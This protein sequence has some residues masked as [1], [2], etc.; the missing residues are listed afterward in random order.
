MIL[1]KYFK[2]TFYVISLPGTCQVVWRTTARVGCGIDYKDLYGGKMTFIVCQYRFPGNIAGL[3]L[4]NIMEL[5]SGGEAYQPS[6]KY[7]IFCCFLI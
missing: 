6:C 7:L 4:Q 3:F 2:S 5:R 1:K